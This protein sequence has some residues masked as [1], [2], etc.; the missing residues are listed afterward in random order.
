[1]AFHVRDFSIFELSEQR[2]KC[3]KR[4]ALRIQ[5]YDR[6]KRPLIL[7]YYELFGIPQLAAVHCSVL[8]VFARFAA[9][10]LTN[11]AMFLQLDDVSLESDLI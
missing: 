1:M 3:K 7:L 4:E 2:G 5:G 6:G 11:S 10:S 8:S 9:S